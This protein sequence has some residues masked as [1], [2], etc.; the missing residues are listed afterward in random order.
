[1]NSAAADIS[2]LRAT[3]MKLLEDLKSAKSRQALKS[4]KKEPVSA[5]KMQDY[6]QKAIRYFMRN[7][8]IGWIDVRNRQFRVQPGLKELPKQINKW[9]KY[10]FV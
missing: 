2:A 3:H 9:K 7:F 4:L 10:P 1:M 5:K 6:I 8:Q